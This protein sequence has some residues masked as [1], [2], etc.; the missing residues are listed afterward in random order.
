MRKKPSQY[1]SGS[2][3]P[4]P[5]KALT[6][7]TIAGQPLALWILLAVGLLAVIILAAIVFVRAAG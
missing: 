5:L 3:L 1:G 4:G 6:S 2:G 7:T